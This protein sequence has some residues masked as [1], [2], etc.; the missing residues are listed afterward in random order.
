MPLS[1]FQLRPE[2]K[3]ESMLTQI[4]QDDEFVYA[5]DVLEIVRTELI[6]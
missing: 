5:D 2:R 3:I 4:V 1:Q 6:K